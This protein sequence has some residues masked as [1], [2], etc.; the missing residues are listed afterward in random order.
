MRVISGSAKGHKLKSFKGLTTR[1]TSDK[2]KEALFS[3]I[4]AFIVASKALE[5]YSGTGGFGIEALSRGSSF[6]DFVENNSKVAALIK[7]NLKHTQ[8]YDRAMVHNIDCF[9]YLN[10]VLDYNIK[11]DIIFMDPPYNKDFITPII[12][13]IKEKNI[14]SNDGILII[15][16]DITDNILLDD[17]E[18]ILYKEKRYGSTVITILKNTKI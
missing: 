17:T 10:K 12:G 13:I 16:R 8:L 4:S 2:V 18:Y 9:M 14:L 11:H 15:E 7:E 3:M 5:L 6:I 1:P